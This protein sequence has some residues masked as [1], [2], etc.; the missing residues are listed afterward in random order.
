MNKQNYKK[1]FLLGFGFF[2][3]SLT[4]S[5]YNSFMPKMLS[6]YLS[7]ATLIG[8][9]M[10][11]DNYF[12]LF[13]QPTVGNLSDNINTKFGKRMPFIMIGMPLAALFLFL[14]PSYTNLFTLIFF[15]VFANLSM[16]IFR[17]P[18]IAL[19]PDLTYPEHRSKANSV[20]NLMGGI[21]AILAYFIGSK[22]WSKNQ[23]YP[24]Y[25][26]ASLML[27]SLL[28]LILFIKEKRDVLNYEINLK[29]KNSLI[30][31][32][33]SLVK[34]QK[35]TL[36]L[37]CAIC[38]WFIGYQ[39]IEAFFTLYGEKFLN[40]SV[41]SA[42]FSFTF[43]SVSFLIFAIPAGIIGTKLGKKRAIS[44]GIL[45]LIICFTVLAFI[46][47]IFIIRIIFIICGMF[48]SFININSYPFVVDMAPRGEIGTYTGFYYMFSAIAAIVSPPLLGRTIDLL[49]YKYMFLYGAG[50]Y[51]LSF[52]F[53][54]FV[55]L[56]NKANLNFKN[57]I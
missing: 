14:I 43:M 28:I 36:F 47:D 34:T 50:F 56:D 8:F 41:P 38:S 55:K 54:L 42:V 16:S 32:L 19:M 49:G 39:G 51:L 30:T 26:A 20:I 37:L 57:H 40:I 15:L 3:I 1:T 48:W 46:R 5:I 11:I 23:A 17:A 6:N 25:M 44:I 7:S 13:I 12:A 24:F 10:T 18:V 33:R 21:G 53:I 9:I 31:N 45:G 2:S 29:A 27:I 22:L 4:W 35:N 52:I